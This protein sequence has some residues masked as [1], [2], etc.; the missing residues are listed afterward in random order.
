MV[1]EHQGNCGSE[2]AKCYQCQMSKLAD[3]LY[4]GRYSIQPKAVTDNNNNEEQ[5]VI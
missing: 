1:K 2:T 3:G 4:S 5:E